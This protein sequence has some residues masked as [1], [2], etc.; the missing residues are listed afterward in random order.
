MKQNKKVEIKSKTRSKPK[1]SYNTNRDYDFLQ[2]I[3]IIFKWAIANH[4]LKRPELELL[5]YLYPMG[6][7]SKNEF[8]VFHK[9]MGIYQQKTFQKM[10]QNG[11]IVMWRPK[12]GRQNALFTLTNKSK[13]LCSRIHKMCVGEIPIPEQAQSNILAKEGEVRIN[14]Y[15]MDIIKKMNKERDKNKEG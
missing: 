15:Y 7:F 8:S 3:R 11:W 2:Y 4:D 12:K 10:I 13:I 9:T 5:L 14:G 6:T 1:T